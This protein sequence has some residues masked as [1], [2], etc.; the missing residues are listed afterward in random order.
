MNEERCLDIE[1]YTV[2]RKFISKK[3]IVEKAVINRG[4]G[5]KQTV[6]VKRFNSEND[7]S[8]EL[9]TL[10][11]LKAKKS[12][13]PDILYSCSKII[14]MEHIEGRLLVD[15]INEPDHDDYIPSLAD[16]LEKLYAGLSDHP[17]GNRNILGDMNLR[18]FIISDIDKNVYRVDLESVKKGD[19]ED[20]AGELCAFCLCY[21]PAF[22]EH[23]IKFA[24]RIYSCLSERFRLSKG[25]FI[26]EILINLEKIEKRREISVPSGIRRTVS[27]W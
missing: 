22:T 27:G 21:D 17:S 20:D 4:A 19:I 13:V 23:K 2:L 18:N 6:V 5:I 26:S 9:E 12:P 1:N 11:L 3:N 8:L 25:K 15:M 14:F 7:F 10:K 24:Y 16:S